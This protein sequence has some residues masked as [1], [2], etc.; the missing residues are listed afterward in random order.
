MLPPQHPRKGSLRSTPLA[1][2]P[3]AEAHARLVAGRLSH[4]RYFEDILTRYEQ[5]KFAGA[6]TTPLE[7]S[8]FEAWAAGRDS[9]RRFWRHKL[10][11]IPYVVKDSIDVAGMATT[12]W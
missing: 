7:P 9:R 2:L 11:G 3:V 4:A 6:F 10:L 5:A 1:D 8:M 12:C